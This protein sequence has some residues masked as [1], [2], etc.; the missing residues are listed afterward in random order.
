MHHEL[1][2][3]A[4][5][6]SVRGDPAACDGVACEYGGGGGGG[7]GGGSNGGGNADADVVV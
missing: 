4:D 2:D 6:P 5:G 3:P 1:R 7:G